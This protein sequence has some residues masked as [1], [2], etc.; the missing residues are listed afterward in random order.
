M[1]YYCT[2]LI[3]AIKYDNEKINIDYANPA[4]GYFTKILRIFFNNTRLK[5]FYFN[6][7]K[8]KQIYFNN[9][10]V[11]IA[12]AEKITFTVRFGDETMGIEDENLACTYTAEEG[13]T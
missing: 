2:S 13:M 7:T 11:F 3:G 8:L 5:N 1:F 10:L 4:I 6:N 12:E 9:K